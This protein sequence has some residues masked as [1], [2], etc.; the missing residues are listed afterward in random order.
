MYKLY[1]RPKKG[2]VTRE[3]FDEWQKRLLDLEDKFEGV[4]D[5]LGIAFQYDSE[6]H[7]IDPAREKK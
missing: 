3:E 1:P 5:L 7:Y 6:A 4:I 2:K